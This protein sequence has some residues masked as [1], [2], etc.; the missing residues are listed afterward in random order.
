MGRST[1]IGQTPGIVPMKSG[2]H[3]NNMLK[4]QHSDFTVAEDTERKAAA[5]KGKTAI[6]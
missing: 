5:K 1:K 4:T 2:V 3:L 6:R